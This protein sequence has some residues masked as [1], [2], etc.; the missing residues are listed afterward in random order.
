MPEPSYPDCSGLRVLPSSS[1][2][3]LIILWS[4]LGLL[5]TVRTN[6]IWKSKVGVT[7]NIFIGGIHDACWPTAAACIFRLDSSNMH[8]DNSYHGP[9][10]RGRD[11]A[12]NAQGVVAIFEAAAMHSGRTIIRM[13][14]TT[15]DPFDYT[16]SALVG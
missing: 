9:K 16:G 7:V 14:G 10:Q 13:D 1:S 5:S 8:D 11:L 2:L 3:S 4:F 15:D 12:A 6:L